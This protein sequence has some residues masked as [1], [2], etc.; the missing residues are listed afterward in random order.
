MKKNNVKGCLILALAALIWGVAFIAQSVGMDHVGSLTFTF[1]RSVLAVVV[2]FPITLL[3]GKKP[4][5]R[6]FGYGDK[7]LLMG[8]SLSGVF[9]FAATACQQIGLELGTKA[10]KAAFITALY[11]VFTPLAGIFF[12]KKAGLPAWLGVALGG[13]GM[14]L[15]CMTGET[16]IE[17]RDLI[18]LLCAVLF[19]GQILVIDRFSSEVDCVR[20][21]CVQFAVAS[22]LSGIAMLIFEEP[23]MGAILDC[24]LPIL[25]A[26]VLSSGVAYTLQIV[27]QK[28]A[29]VTPATLTM[30]LESV[31]AAVA[32]WI[33]LHERM[34][35]PEI[36]G[37]VLIFIAIVVAQL[38]EPQRRKRR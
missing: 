38:P 28:Y 18:V 26:G 9:L 4:M 23:R 6:A 11:I 13:V 17:R 24:A 22:V 32:G 27:G 8:G 36:A 7:K 16:G 1:C 29:D 14:Y 35:A 15:L 2:L 3:L 5:G 20:M 37:C 31:F 10:G 12:G 19:T 30:S 21:S 34:N 33:L 25:Y